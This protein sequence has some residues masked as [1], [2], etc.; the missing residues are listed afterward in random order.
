M[1]WTKNQGYFKDEKE[2][3]WN[4]IGVDGEREWAAS[5]GR[6]GWGIAVD[7]VSHA[8]EGFTVGLGGEAKTSSLFCEGRLWGFCFP[9]FLGPLARANSDSPGQT[10]GDWVRPNKDRTHLNYNK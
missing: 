7:G 6:K 9:A 4:I 10:V 1:F 8:S 3:I 2:I 5:G